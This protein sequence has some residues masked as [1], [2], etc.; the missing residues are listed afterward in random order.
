M[1]K[2]GFFLGFVSLLAINLPAQADVPQFVTYSGRLTDG[3]AWGASTQL[4]LTLGI[5]DAVSQ[6]EKL[7]EATFD[8]VVVQDG[9]FSVLLGDGDDPTTQEVETDHNVTE[10]FANHGETWI[11]VTVGDSAELSPR[12]A[13]GS[14]PYAVRADNSDNLGGVDVAELKRQIIQELTDCPPFYEK[15]QDSNILATGYYCRRGV[16]EMVKVGDFWIDRYEAVIVDEALYNEGACNGSGTI[17]GRSDGDA[18]AAGFVRNGSDITTRLYACSLP[19]ENP[20]RYITWFQAQ[21]VC[22]AAGKRLCTNAQW[23]LAAFG[24]ADPSASDPGD[25]SEICNIWSNSKPAGSTWGTTNETILTG[26]ASQCI[27][28]YGAYD[29]VGNLWEWTAN[30]YGQGVNGVGGFQ[31]NDGEFHGDGYWN[32]DNAQNNGTYNPSTPAFPASALRSGNW[33]YGSQSGVF[34]LLL[35]NGPAHWSLSIGTRCCKR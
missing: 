27:S 18:H 28:R 20:S 7:W 2:L 14:V 34:A 1:R 15:V 26:S 9:Y 22:G 35:R 32:V 12:Q 33:N 19:N 10:V 4:S 6:G 21:E 31:A 5:Y 30:W 3:T 24:T 17:Y 29:M 11:G 13:V 16:D 25:D 23:Q 8:P